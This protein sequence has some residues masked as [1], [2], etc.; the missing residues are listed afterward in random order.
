MKVESIAAIDVGSNAVRLLINSVE[1][2]EE[3]KAL[4]KN[5]YVRAPVRLGEDVFSGGLIGEEKKG[6]LMETMR[7]FLHLM[8]VFNVVHYRACATSAMREAGNGRAV[9]DWLLAQTGIKI[10]IITGREEAE[11]IFDAGDLA[12]LM[13]R[14]KSYLHVDVGGGSTEVVV[15]SDGQKRDAYSF[16]IGTLRMLAG[17]I[18]PEAEKEFKKE[19]NLIRNRYSPWGI[20]ASGGNINKTLKLLGKKDGDAV[21]YASLSDFC[22][23]LSALTF[24]ERLKIYRMNSYRADVIVPALRIF[25]SIGEVCRIKSYTIPKVGLVDG[26]IR[27]LYSGKIAPDR[28]PGPAV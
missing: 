10:N 25:L 27:Q 19:L 28:L 18:S 20:I 16:P 24:E 3:R 5:A 13:D 8:H 4:K 22:Q 23:T 17:A 6:R 11:L 26:I 2:Y 21:S 9:A 15:Y 1:D 14:G 7:A 12:D